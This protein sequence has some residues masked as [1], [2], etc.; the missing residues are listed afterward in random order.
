MIDITQPKWATVRQA[1]QLN[2]SFTEPALRYL[3]F[4]SKKNGLE[5]CLRRIGKKILINLEQFDKWID[6]NGGL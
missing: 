3:I 1:S 4:Q 6:N 2:P 5:V